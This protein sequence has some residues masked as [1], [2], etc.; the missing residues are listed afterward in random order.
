MALALSNRTVGKQKHDKHIKTC[1]EPHGQVK[2]RSPLQ[3]P[4]M[5]LKKV[6]TTLKFNEKKN[7][8]NLTSV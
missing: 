2:I 6:H 4:R 8:W 5:K 3:K 7:G 1:T